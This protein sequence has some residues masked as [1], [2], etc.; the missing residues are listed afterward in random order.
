MCQKS[1]F[2]LE[3][4]EV[5]KYYKSNRKSLKA[6]DG[7][8]LKIN[9]GEIV[10]LV[11]ES[12]CGKT[13][14]AKLMLNL[15]LPTEGTVMF[16]GRDLNDLNK[17]EYI[18]YRRNTQ[19]I[20]QDS[21]SSLNPKMKIHSIIGEP[22]INFGIKNKDIRKNLVLEVMNNVGLDYKYESL[23]P[24]EL[25]G[26]QRQRVNIARAFILK[27]KIIICDEP[28]SSLD[29]SM[30]SQILNL[31]K[32]LKDKYNSGYLFISHDLAVVKFISS[33]IVVM[34][35]GKIVEIIQSKDLMEKVVHPYTK[36]LIESVPVIN[37][38][39][40]C[41]NHIVKCELNFKKNINKGCVFGNRC[42]YVKEICVS[43][44]PRLRVVKGNHMVAC[45]LI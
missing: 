19:V 16:Q 37:K 30:Q 25:S 45:H 23:Y 4:M 43:E 20:F 5:K 24:M 33:K 42:I 6:V 31:M 34:Y 38:E 41:E 29:V 28:T 10:G 32:D 17:S 12:G 27:P 3:L 35:G 39:Q 9:S 11:G 1:E 8:S 14:I 36:A 2:S 22:L 44:V 15:E 21:Y 13:T 18:D 7:V 26:G 40:N